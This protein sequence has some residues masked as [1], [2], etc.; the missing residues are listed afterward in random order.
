[1]STKQVV[2]LLRRSFSLFVHL[3]VMASLVTS[4]ATATGA[5]KAGDF[6][7]PNRLPFQTQAAEKAATAGFS[8]SSPATWTPDKQVAADTYSTD[9]PSMSTDSN[10]HLWMAVECGD[11]SHEKRGIRLMQSTDRGNTWTHIS[12]I[13]MAYNLEDPDIAIDPYTDKVYIVYAREFSVGVDWD[14]LYGI[15]TP[16]EGTVWGLV[17]DN[18]SDYDYNPSITCEYQYDDANY[19]YVSYTCA[20]DLDD[21]DLMFAR[22]ID[23]GQSWVTTKLH[24]GSDSD[25]YIESDITNAEGRVYLAYRHSADFWD[26]VGESDI[27]VDWSASYGSSW[28]QAK[29]V[30]NSPRAVYEPS[31]AATHGGHT[32]VVAYMYKYSDNDYD[33]Q[34]AYSTDSGITWSAYNALANDSGYHEVWPSLT[35]DGWGFTGNDIYGKIHAVYVTKDGNLWYRST[36]YSTPTA[37][38]PTEKVGDPGTINTYYPAVVAITTQLRRGVWYPCVAWKAGYVHY[39]TMA[40]HPAV[41]TSAATAVGTTT[42]TLNGNLSDWGTAGSVLTSF[43][44]GTSISYGNETTPESSWGTGSFSANLS[45]L[46]PDTTY[47]FRAKAVGDG[48]SYGDDMTFTT[49]TTPPTVTTSAAT[50]VGTVSATL[51][52]NLSSLGTALSVQVS[53]EWGPTIG[54]GTTTTSQTYIGTGD[55]SAGISGLTP[56]T[57]YH[58]RA[59]AAGDGT[60]YGGDMTF[61]TDV[62]PNQGPS[63]PSNT[64]PTD[65]AIGVSLTP[66]LSSSAFSDPDAGD[67]HAASQWQMITSPWDYASP[68]FDSGTDTKNLTGITV[69]SGKLAYSTLYY[70]RVRHQ[71]NHGAWSAWSLETSFTTVSSSGDTTPPAAVADLA[72]TAASSTSVTLTWTAPGDDGNTGT[73]S[74]Y[75]IRYSTGT[76]TDA[77]WGSASLCSGEPSPGAAGATQTFTIKD[78]SPDTTYYFAV[79]TADEV[80][81]WSGLSNIASRKTE[82]I[83]PDDQPPAQPAGVSPV[84]G[85]TGVSLTPIMEASAFSDPDSGDTHAASQWQIDDDPWD[86]SSP[87]FDS[88]TDTT[89]L[90]SITVP[91][92]KL[93]DSTLYYWRVRYQDQHGVWSDWSDEMHFTTTGV[94]NQQPNQ[95]DNTAPATGSTRVSVTP[96]LEA[97][98]FSDPDSGDTHAAS[99]WQIDDDPWDFSSPAFDSGTDTTNL[100]SISIPS[101]KLTYSTLYYWRVRYQDSHGA[102]SAW[103]EEAHF[104]TMSASADSTPPTTPSIADDGVT[105]TSTSELHAVWT[106]SDAESGIAEYLYAVGTSPGG[107]DVLDWTSAGAAT[108]KT[109]TGLSMTPGQTYYV[110]VKAVNGQGLT[111]EV[112][113]SDGITV[114]ADDGEP[115]PKPGDKGGVPFWLWI[116]VALGVVGAGAGGFLFWQRLKA[117]SA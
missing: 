54:Y 42:A 65:G 71:D 41:A 6:G 79:M 32:V 29:V 25:V 18:D 111:S 67:T 10:G 16:G 94:P 21:Q 87:A 86:F 99:Q 24:G 115:E 31:V 58:F 83:P 11:S 64:S 102:W 63:Q 77:N 35:V 44:W 103:S 14:I 13:Y 15:H 12:S 8:P 112:G 27:W 80:S 89:N 9:S 100:T 38:S 60:A 43:E 30:D 97:S 81:N 37:W 106:S 104:N 53:F 110:S 45:S 22:S 40:L 70:W 47:H 78:L 4:L 55:F 113:S 116:L 3:A 101:G 117:K 95:P 50:G 33:V 72:A 7:T 88:G 20:I 90:T 93:I 51:N 69:P 96:I 57:A 98:A 34:Y 76:I 114:A 75:D 105:T 59:K 84:D 1:M 2:C 109:I 82:A 62:L 91:S 85:A 36:D 19:L 17:I 73:A 108:E 28:V 48:T 49:G 46:L 92:G 68:A 74:I 56:G 107:N 26:L 66:M 39:S 5:R 52:G 23:H 61:T